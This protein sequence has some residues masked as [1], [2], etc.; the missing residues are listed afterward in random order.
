M[1]WNCIVSP[2]LPLNSGRLLSAGAQFLSC[3]FDETVIDHLG[4]IDPLGYPCAFP[5]LVDES[6]EPIHTH[7]PVAQLR[8]YHVIINLVRHRATLHG[9]V[10]TY[11]VQGRVLVFLVVTLFAP[12]ERRMD[13]YIQLF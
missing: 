1:S 10:F 7:G 12:A 11:D 3:L 5:L 4:R 2:E 9:P 8:S 13:Y 6:L